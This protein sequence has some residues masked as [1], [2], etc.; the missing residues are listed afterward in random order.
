[1]RDTDHHSHTILMHKLS[2]IAR[3]AFVPYI[4]RVQTHTHIADALDLD[5]MFLR[6]LQQLS[7]SRN[8]AVP[9][10]SSSLTLAIPSAIDGAPA[11]LFKC[12]IASQIMHL[13]PQLQRQHSLQGQ[14]GQCPVQLEQVRAM[15]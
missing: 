14:T 3:L 5:R 1:M 11:A 8:Q 12:T 2:C 4:A 6:V 9:K 15:P 10:M 7:H 13:Q